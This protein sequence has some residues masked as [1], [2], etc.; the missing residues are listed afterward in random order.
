MTQLT[1]MPR[2]SNKDLPNTLRMRKILRMLMLALVVA[3]PIASL[4]QASIITTSFAG[5][6]PRQ[7]DGASIGD[8]TFGGDWEA[9]N[10]DDR[11]MPAMNA[12]SR[13]HSISY[14]NGLFNFQ[15]MSLGG[16]TWDGVHTGRY[17]VARQFVLNFSFL[18]EGGHTLLS[19]SMTLPNS[20][21]FLTYTKRVAGVHAILF[22]PSGGSFDADGQW[23][24]DF[25]P[26]L[27][28]ITS[29]EVP[30]PASVLLLATGLIALMVLRTGSRD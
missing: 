18:D 28:S 7:L 17:R 8:W 26:R 11:K 12:G 20:D 1:R 22:R 27:A 21:A 2:H 29:S 13:T 30:E 23:G 25:V 14:N 24:N 9:F 16:R 15:S 19:D 3:L 5:I 10:A 6:G 4:A